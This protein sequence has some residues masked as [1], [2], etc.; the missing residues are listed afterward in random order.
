LVID[1]LRRHDAE[2]DVLRLKLT[3]VANAQST[4]HNKHH[5]GPKTAIDC[6]AQQGW[7]TFMDWYVF[8]VAKIHYAYK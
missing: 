6:E 2:Q 8:T 1:L 4:V 3:K 5:R 7:K